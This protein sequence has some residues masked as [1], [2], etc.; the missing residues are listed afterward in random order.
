MNDPLQF[1]LDDA[2]RRYLQEMLRAPGYKVLNAI[3]EAYVDTAV[4]TAIQQ[5]RLDPLA[6]SEAIARAW[7]YALIAEQ[8][9]DAMVRG[10]QFELQL[11]QQHSKPPSDPTELA[12]LAELRRRHV[13]LG[14]LD[15]PPEE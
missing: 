4:E 15:P 3:M 11:L 9:R 1:E 8:F 14:E 10:V 13:V 2:Q 12:K 6:N 5:S 7:A